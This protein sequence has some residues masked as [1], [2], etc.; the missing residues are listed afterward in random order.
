[1]D[2]ERPE[3]VK[4]WFYAGPTPHFGFNK[5]VPGPKGSKRKGRQIGR[6]RK[7]CEA[8]R[9]R[10]Q[11]ERNALRKLKKHVR[12]HPNDALSAKA[13]SRKSA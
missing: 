7:S 2:S 1:M 9:S 6:N 11:R 8:Y 4:A 12:R 10:G 5:K 3:W 13:L